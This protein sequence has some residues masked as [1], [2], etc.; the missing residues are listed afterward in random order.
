[1]AR[2]GSLP[3][4]Y[5]FRSCTYFSI[6]VH[7]DS[8][9]VLLYRQSE[10][11]KAIQASVSD[12]A[13][14]RRMDPPSVQLGLPRS[15]WTTMGKKPHHSSASLSSA[16]SRHSA[17]PERLERQKKDDSSYRDFSL[18]RASCAGVIL[19]QSRQLALHI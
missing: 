16:D 15:A 9:S 1:M 6:D 3:G 12:M 5:G 2:A 18:P 8:D 4:N 19:A 14:S 7:R 10:Y 11:Q 17:G 13:M